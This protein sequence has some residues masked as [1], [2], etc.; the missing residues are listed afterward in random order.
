[1]PLVKA[2]F[3]LMEQTLC[4][5]IINAIT[6]TPAGTPIEIIARV[7]SENLILEVADRGPG[8]PPDELER[9]FESFHRAPSARPGGTGLGLAI[10]K[11]FVEVQGGSIKAANRDGGG[12]VFAIHLSVVDTPDLS[13]ELL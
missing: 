12:A 13:D 5:L 6:H 4:N 7:E 9:I 2:D 8:L 3:V 11:G 1:L 10:V